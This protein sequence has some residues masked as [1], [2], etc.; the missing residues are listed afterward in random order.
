M[1]LVSL[2][3][4]DAKPVCMQDIWRTFARSHDEPDTLPAVSSEG[5]LIGLAPAPVLQLV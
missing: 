5:R 2:A 3:F 4:C 1:A